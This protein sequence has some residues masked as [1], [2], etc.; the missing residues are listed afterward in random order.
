MVDPN[1]DAELA[2]GGMS[3]TETIVDVCTQGLQRQNAFVVGLVA[4]DLGAA[5]TSA[6]RGLDSFCAGFHGTAHSLLHCAAEGNTILKLLGNVLSDELSIT[7]RALNFNNIQGNLC[8]G[9]SLK[10]FLQRLNAGGFLADDDARLRGQD[11]DLDAAG[12]TLDLDLGDACL[13]E[14][15]FQ[16]ITDLAILNPEYS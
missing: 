9:H 1:L 6:D 8:A 11:D 5:D 3:F 10:F 7:L 13:I 4:S 16:V 15:L 2:I 12:C 14:L